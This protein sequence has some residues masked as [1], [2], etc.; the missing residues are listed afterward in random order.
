MASPSGLPKMV[1]QTFTKPQ[2]SDWGFVAKENQLKQN[3]VDSG[4]I[5]DYLNCPLLRET[6]V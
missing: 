4:K 6:T 2:F 5:V 1:K 3:Q